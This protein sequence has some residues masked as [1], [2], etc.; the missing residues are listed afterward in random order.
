MVYFK[1]ITALLIPLSLY[2]CYCWKKKVQEAP[3]KAAPIV[4]DFEPPLHT[5]TQ[6]MDVKQATTKIKED[7]QQKRVSFSAPPSEEKKK[8]LAPFK[9]RLEADAIAVVAKLAVD[10]IQSEAKKEEDKL[11]GE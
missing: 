5:K 7:A 10:V 1:V 8:H 2:G 3:K 4:F 6:S 9:N 11:R